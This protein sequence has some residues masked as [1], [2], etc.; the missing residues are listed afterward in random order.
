MDTVR[1][2]RLKPYERLKLRS[3]KRQSTN[4][5][6]SRHAR[7]IL[8]SVGGVSNR[9][10]RA[11]R[12]HPAM[13]EDHR[14]SIQQRR[15]RWHHVVSLLLRSWRSA[16][17]LRRDHRTDRR[18]RP[19]LAQ[20]ADRDELLVGPQAASLSYR[21]EDCRLD[22]RQSP[23]RNPARA[24]SAVRTPRLEGLYDL[25]LAQIPGVRRCT[26]TASWGE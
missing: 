6:N 10:M 9:Q 15:D 21:T 1:A 8:L 5:V 25:N 23:S 7:I 22:Q 19:V 2:R 16:Q 17:V 18:D 11:G 20:G 24:Q 26:S 12:L 3:M 14:P 4:A 13:G